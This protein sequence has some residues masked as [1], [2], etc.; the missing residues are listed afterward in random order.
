MGHVMDLT[1]GQTWGP[2]IPPPV[3]FK[4]VHLTTAP[5]VKFQARS[6]CNWSKINPIHFAT[7]QIQAHYISNWSNIKPIHLTTGQKSSR[8]IEP[9]S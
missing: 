8:S 5:P 3:N 2:G 7:G 6:F 1:T 9:P 4:P